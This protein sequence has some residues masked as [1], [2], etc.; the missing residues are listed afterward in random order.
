MFVNVLVGKQSTTAI[1]KIHDF[2]YVTYTRTRFVKPCLCY[3]SVRHIY[4][5][6]VKPS[7]SFA[8]SLYHF[9]R[10]CNVSIF[11]VD[12][13]LLNLRCLVNLLFLWKVYTV[14]KLTL[15]KCIY[16]RQILINLS[17][18]WICINQEI[19]LTNKHFCQL[20]IFGGFRLNTKFGKSETI[21][22]WLLKIVFAKKR[23]YSGGLQLGKY[24]N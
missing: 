22:K 4:P 19:F 8:F 6:F 7:T 1:C 13:L 5:F 20:L 11:I 23:L 14:I 17:E 9:R 12:T 15:G 10:L 21:R 16:N 3:C 18:I 24:E 2:E